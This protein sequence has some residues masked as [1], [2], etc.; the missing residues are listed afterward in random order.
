[1]DIF[2]L[3][4]TNQLV[5]HNTQLFLVMHYTILNITFVIQFSSHINSISRYSNFWIQNCSDIFST[6][7]FG[8]FN[9]L[10]H[11]VWAFG[12]AQI[13]VLVRKISLLAACPRNQQMFQLAPRRPASLQSVQVKSTVSKYPCLTLHLLKPFLCE[14]IDKVLAHILLATCELVKKQILFAGH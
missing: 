4:V 11:I 10:C 6:L 8:Y 2:I 7:V 14:T 12:P 13:P 5:V 1:M 3:F 9:S